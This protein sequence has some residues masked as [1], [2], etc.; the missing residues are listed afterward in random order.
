MRQ[1]VDGAGCAIVNRSEYFFLVCDH[2]GRQVGFKSGGCVLVGICVELSLPTA[3]AAVQY[4]YPGVP[5]ITQH[6]PGSGCP[7][8]RIGG[9]D[10][11]VAVIVDAQVADC[12]RQFCLV[13]QHEHRGRLLF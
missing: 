13:W 8:D 2:G 3:S 7:H 6:P 9:V 12:A 11:D 5:G 10:N 1:R 4:P